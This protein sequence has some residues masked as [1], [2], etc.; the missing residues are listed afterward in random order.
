MKTRSR[1]IIGA[2]VVLVLI[3]IGLL[4]LR[5]L[6]VLPSSAAEEIAADL[7]S[8]SLESP[9]W[10]TADAQ[11]SFDAVVADLAEA[12]P[13]RPP[14]RGGA[15]GDPRFTSN[16]EPQSH[17][18]SSRLLSRRSSPLPPEEV[19]QGFDQMEATLLTARN[20]AWLPVILDA[21]EETAQPVVV[22]AGLPPSRPLPFCRRHPLPRRSLFW[23]CAPGRIPFCWRTARRT[24]NIFLNR[25][26]S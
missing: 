21:V 15:G 13:T 14:L 16:E 11:R 1:R 22:A 8:G 26:E 3:G 23:A 12:V 2:A 18:S 4:A 25:S 20:E 10:S 19:D 5:T 24:W 17:T 9:V 6:P 7:T